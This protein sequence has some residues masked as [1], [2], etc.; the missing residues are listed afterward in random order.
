MK[1]APFSIRA[2]ARSFGYAWE[3]IIAFV[4]R[5]HNAWLHC[6]ATIAVAVLAFVVDLTNTE[7]IALVFAV[8]FVWVAEMFNTCIEHIMDFI[9]TERKPAIKFIKDLSAGAVL[10]AAIT[11]LIVGS[12]IFIPKIF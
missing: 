5:E 9:S 11:A 1:P 3:G 4:R 8:G 10:V 6:I 12:I 7:I 2:R